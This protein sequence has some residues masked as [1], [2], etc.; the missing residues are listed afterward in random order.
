MFHQ[1]RHAI[2]ANACHSSEALC[3]HVFELIRQ[4]CLRVGLS[5]N[6]QSCPLVVKDTAAQ[7]TLNNLSVV[8]LPAHKVTRFNIDLRIERYVASNGVDCLNIKTSA[9]LVT[10]HVGIADLAPI[11]D[12]LVRMH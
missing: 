7:F 12:R 4:D 2:P 10:N 5:F 9:D 11:R 1:S 3:M 6:E 8:F